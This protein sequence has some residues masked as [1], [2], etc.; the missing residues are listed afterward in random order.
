VESRE[1]R[2]TEVTL[3]PRGKSR[4]NSPNPEKKGT[5]KGC[6]LYE[7]MKAKRRRRQTRLGTR[8]K[9]GEGKEGTAL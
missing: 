5:K 9:R 4:G 8:G 7:L 3:Q 6:S 2:L 1:R